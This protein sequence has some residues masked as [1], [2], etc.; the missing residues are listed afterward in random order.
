M[1]EPRLTRAELVER[2]AAQGYHAVR[3]PKCGAPIASPCDT[4]NGWPHAA[5]IKLGPPM[6]RGKPPR[7]TASRSVY[8]IPT[9]FESNRRRH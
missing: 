8:A 9:A 1:T 7:K 3:C 2:A 4:P 6:K 5:R